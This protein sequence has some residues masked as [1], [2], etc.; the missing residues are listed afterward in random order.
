[1]K[2][3]GNAHRIKD[4]GLR[5]PWKGEIKKYD[6]YKRTP[7]IPPFQGFIMD[8]YRFTGLHPVLRYFA[9]SGL[10]LNFLTIP[11]FESL[12]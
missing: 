2:A 10:L 7:I 5:Q 4:V 9:L 1:M 12:E 8:I 11:K 3:M 6:Y